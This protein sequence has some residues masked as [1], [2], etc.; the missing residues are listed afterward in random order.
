[1]DPVVVAM[2]D[3]PEVDCRPCPRQC[4]KVATNHRHHFHCVV[5]MDILVPHQS[6]KCHPGQEACKDHSFLL[7]YDASR[8]GSSVPAD[9]ASSS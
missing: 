7:Q 2:E 1:M 5:V 4:S 8:A 9:S 3:L 6:L